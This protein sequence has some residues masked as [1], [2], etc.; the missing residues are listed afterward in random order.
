MRARLLAN[1]GVALVA[2]VGTSAIHL[3]NVLPTIAVQTCAAA[4]AVLIGAAFCVPARWHGRALKLLVAATSIV[5]TIPVT[6]ALLR[7]TVGPTLHYRPEVTFLGQ[8]P[9]MPTCYI[10]APNVTFKGT[11]Y[12]DLA[13]MT[14]KPEHREPRQVTF[15][16][17]VSG[18]RNDPAVTERPIDV[19]VLGDSF[20]AGAGVMQDEVFSTRVAQQTGLNVRNLSISPAGPWAEYMYL[21]AEI[22]RMKLQEGATLIWAL[23]TGNDIED[24]YGPVAENELPWSSR[25]EARR[26]ALLNFQRRSPLREYLKRRTETGSANAVLVTELADPASGKP[27]LFYKPNVLNSGLTREQVLQQENYPYLAKTM[28]ALCEFAA[29]RRLNV[30]VFVLPTKEEIYG[31]MLQGKEPWSVPTPRAGFSAAVEELARANGMEFHDT[32]PDFLAA[33]PGEY[34]AGRLLWWRDDTHINGA[35]H[36]VIANAIVQSLRGTPPSE[37]IPRQPAPLADRAKNAPVQR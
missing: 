14:N 31:W 26:I 33:A 17:D 11:T 22:D 9:P 29:Q 35:G 5:V 16:T 19:I 32:K 1:T 10:Y 23:Y 15:Q 30:K 8:W 3:M 27:V 28:A 12:G 37:S 21:R 2:V 6:D 34:P 7:L 24:P 13:A 36:A 25:R 4:V 20:G 18:F